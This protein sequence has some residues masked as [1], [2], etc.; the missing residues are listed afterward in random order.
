MSRRTEILAQLIAA[1]LILIVPFTFGY[2]HGNAA[3]IATCVGIIL[4]NA[5]TRAYLQPTCPDPVDPIDDDG[6]TEYRVPNDKLCKTPSGHWTNRD[7]Y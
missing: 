6:F 7:I 4:G 3:F 2:M 1:A 5:A